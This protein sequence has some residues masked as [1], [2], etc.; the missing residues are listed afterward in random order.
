MK[1]IAKTQF[2]KSIALVGALGVLNAIPARAESFEFAE[3]EPSEERT[4][5]VRFRVNEMNLQCL[6]LDNEKN[7]LQDHFELILHAPEVVRHFRILGNR[8]LSKLYGSAQLCANARTVILKE[9]SK[10]GG[11]LERTVRIEYSPRIYYW[12]GDVCFDAEREFASLFLGVETGYGEIGPS[13]TGHARQDHFKVEDY[14]CPRP[15][16][17]Y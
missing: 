11:R 9:A 14:L 3:K 12:S 8:P 17:P 10:Q 6:P 5:R 7:F 16:Y 4:L 2:L 13:V 15:E 1:K